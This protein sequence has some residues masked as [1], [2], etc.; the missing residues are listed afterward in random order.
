MASVVK[1]GEYVDNE[2]KKPLASI[3]LDPDNLWSYMKIHGDAGWGSFPSYL[4][5][6]VE[7][8]VDRFRA[9]GLRTTIFIV[10]Q[11]AALAKNAAAMRA[12]ADSGHEIGNH[13][14]SHEPWF[15]TYSREEIEREIA[16]AETGSWGA[17]G[18]R[19][20]WF[21]GPGFGRSPGSGRAWAERK[22][23][24]DAPTFPTCLGPLAPA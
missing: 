4:D 20:C 1:P 14:F 17:P 19:P 9:H 12:L 11:D 15:H 7:I 3:S 23:L 2:T 22:H 6:V 13:S 24:Y 8:I 21:R 5:E 16:D 10:G 18:S